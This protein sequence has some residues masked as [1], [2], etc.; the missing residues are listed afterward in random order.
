MSNELERRQ[1]SVPR[2]VEKTG[3]KAIRYLWHALRHNLG[4]KVLALFLAVALW[5]GLIT[6]DP[7]LTREK[8][9]TDVQVNIIGLDTLKKNGYIVTSD[10]TTLPPTARLK[11]DVPQKEYANVTAANY[12]VRVDLSRITSDGVQ[13]LK[14]AATSTSTYG[15]VEEIV[16]D[17]LEVTVEA[18][19]T[20]YRIPVTVVR[21]GDPP[22]GFYSTTPKLD[23]P[24]VAVSGPAS[25]VERVARAVVTFDQSTL[26]ARE[27]PWP[28]SVPFALVDSFGKEVNSDL[29]QVTSE[30]VFLKNVLVEQTLYNTKTVDLSQVAL[31]EGTPA[32][33]Y[34]VK[35]VSATPSK[36]V[37][38]GRW[39]ALDQIESLFLESPVN[40][41]GAK[42]S[43]NSVIRVSQPAGIENLSAKSVTVTV[44]I[45]PVMINRSF[46]N[47]RV[48]AQGLA[49]GLSASLDKTRAGI[50][51]NGPKL[52]VDALKASDITVTADLTGLAEGVHSVPLLVSVSGG[53]GTAYTYATDPAIVTATISAK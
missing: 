32:A 17:T 21:E 16:P 47:L 11:V 34:R 15:T 3:L 20:R 39:E 29:I 46:D 22:A 33:G 40:I 1:E 41:N 13:K 42:E 25:L 18:Y 24:L 45:E 43:F 36:I 10:L 26:P 31:T 5:A 28:S 37:A 35:S 9:F 50:T 44:E 19:I 51:I 38:A 30:S 14:I 53:E 4:W 27:G 49:V 12:N 52:W 6:Q 48:N 8:T 7:T 2:R 23:P